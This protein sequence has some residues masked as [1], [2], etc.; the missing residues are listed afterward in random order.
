MNPAAPS[1]DPGDIAVI[2]ALHS[3]ADAPALL[4]C[5]GAQARQPERLIL[6]LAAGAKEETALQK[7][8]DAAQLSV[9]TQ[10]LCDEKFRGESGCWNEGLQHAGEC[11]YLYFLKAGYFPDRYFL[12]RA[13]QHLDRQ[14]TATAASA[15]YLRETAEIQHLESAAALE[16]NYCLWLF[17][18]GADLV[19]R[20]LFRTAA[21]QD[22][23]SFNLEVGNA[24]DFEFCLQVAARGEWLHVADCAVR[25]AEEEY[26]RSADPSDER[27]RE[28]ALL[29]EMYFDNLGF[30]G[31]F[32]RPVHRALFA[33]KW[34]DA[35]QWFIAVRHF[36][37][38]KQ[39]LRR[40]LAWKILG[41]AALWRLLLLSL[42]QSRWLSNRLEKMR[43]RMSVGRSPLPD[44]PFS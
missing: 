28:Y 36:E 37:D 22:F 3:A 31:R 39:C 14:P 41:N 26:A 8:L 32:P 30:R 11:A 16:Q 44:I 23:R 15:D 5:L 20:T 40:S 35:A 19:P 24:R 1:P 12:Q 43:Q 33:R 42:Y 34:H 18:N 6:A 2:V 38:A 27:D 7:A 17:Q 29:C 10:L 21:V 13:A 9:S 4:E 25:T